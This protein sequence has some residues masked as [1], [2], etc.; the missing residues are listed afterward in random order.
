MISFSLIADAACEEIDEAIL[1]SGSV[2]VRIMSLQ[3][4]LQAIHIQSLGKFSLM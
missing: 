2:V 4:L 3:L 1:R